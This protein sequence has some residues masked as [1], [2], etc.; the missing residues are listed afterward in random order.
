MKRSSTTAGLV[1]AVLA[2][3]SFGTSGAFG[4]ALID[5]GWSPIAAVTGRVLIGGIVLLPFAI[6][7]LRGRWIALWHA[8]TR[9]LLMALVGVA[10][11]QLVYFSS[12]KLFPV[13]DAV[14]IEY[15]A[16]VILVGWFWARTRRIPKAVVLIGSVVALGGLVL[17][18]SPQAGTSLPALGLILAFTGAI[19]CSVY[20]VIAA[21]PSDDL[22]PVGLACVSILLGGIALLIVGATGLLPFT[23]TFTTVNLF[24]GGVPWWIPLLVLGV[25]ACGFAYAASITASELL[26]SR[27][28]SFMGLLEVVAAALYAW[29]LLG[30]DLRWPQLVGG[31]L[32]LGGIAFVRSDK[33]VDAPLEPLAVTTEIPVIATPAPSVTGTTS[34]LTSTTAP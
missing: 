19:G 15:L 7:Q 33:G 6:H 1:I 3:L 16:P 32:I 28:A 31:V 27:L 23:M 18:V 2:A 5:A 14:L 20:Y 4:K 11:T 13:S 22:P 10:A 8:R 29:L 17:V 34:E 30:Q 12:V 9:V 26:G 21:M 24:G 25:V